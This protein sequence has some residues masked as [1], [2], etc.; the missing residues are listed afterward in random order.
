MNTQANGDGRSFLLYHSYF[1]G[2]VLC[3]VFLLDFN[4]LGRL[5]PFPLFT[6]LARPLLVLLHVLSGGKMLDSTE[7]GYIF[8]MLE[9]VCI[10]ILMK[11]K[12]G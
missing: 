3:L 4:H 9:C 11:K 10:R 7:T 1:L 5:F 2:L 12:R 6:F 8:R